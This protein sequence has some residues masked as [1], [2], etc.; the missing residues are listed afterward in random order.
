MNLKKNILSFCLFL[1]SAL[2][3]FGCS[4]TH[5]NQEYAKIENVTYNEETFM[6]T[7]DKVPG[8]N[9]YEIKINGKKFYV[10]SNEYFYIPNR[11][12]TEFQVMPSRY[13]GDY[14]EYL[15]WSDV[16]THD[17]TKSEDLLVRTYLLAD[18]IAVGKEVVEVVGFYIE[19][20]TFYMQV[21]YHY[22]DEDF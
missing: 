7:W 16:Y 12:I 22:N 19:E 18:K 2:F 21:V 17:A 4:S 3:L 14:Y 11:P 20:K 9:Q 5:Q 1:F 8:A 13:Y 6:F 10:E 15:T